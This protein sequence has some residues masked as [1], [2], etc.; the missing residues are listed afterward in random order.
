VEDQDRPT[1]GVVSVAHRGGI[2][3]GVPE[4][5]M[6]A[7]RAA[8][9]QGVDAIEIDL[10]GTKDGAVVIMHDETVDRTTNGI[11]RV[12]DQTLAELKRLD[13]GQGESIPT[14]EEVLQF[15]A[16][17]C[18][19][20]LLD[21]K[22]SPDLDKAKVVRLT[23]AHDAVLNVIVG[24]RSIEDLRAFQA[25]NPSLQTLGFI[26]SVEEIEPTV[27]AGIDIIR[28]WPEWI[29]DDP[30]LIKRVHALGKPVW[31]TAGAATREEIEKL[32]TL[33]VNGILSDHPAL[34]KAVLADLDKSRGR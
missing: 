32:I 22:A 34:M 27:Q 10:R 2:V 14:Y 30:G 33:G 4:N 17:T 19:T 18:V 23:E 15:L 6:A 29:H 8:V 28:L 9:N 20:L 25:L 31:T 13:A 16:G 3:A 24:T 26:E 7:F 5:T 1:W 12:A 11:G 21:I